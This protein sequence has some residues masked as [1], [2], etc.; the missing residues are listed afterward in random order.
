MT[1]KKEKTKTK[2]ITKKKVTRSALGKAGGELNLKK[3]MRS[4][5][6]DTLTPPPLP[7]SKGLTSP[8]EG[9]SSLTEP[10]SAIPVRFDPKVVAEKVWIV[11]LNS[12]ASST[13]ETRFLLS[14]NREFA[15]KG[16]KEGFGSIQTLEPFNVVHEKII[17][18]YH[19]DIVRIEIFSNLRTLTFSSYTDFLE[20]LELD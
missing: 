11:L 5:I 17:E 8:E 6:S 19:K 15:L 4:R 20:W 1:M 16:D 18:T 13:F 12:D 2:K 14:D 3:A 9:T 10:L 7:P